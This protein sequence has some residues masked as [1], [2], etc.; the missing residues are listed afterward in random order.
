M[1]IG[2][3]QLLVIAVL[4]VM[5]FGASRL[6]DVGRGLGQGVRAFKRGM[7]G[8]PDEDAKPT[9]S[10]K[11][12]DVELVEE[13]DPADVDEGVPMRKRIAARKPPAKKLA[14]KNDP[15]GDERS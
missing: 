2:P 10:Q 3:L 4:V 11:P 6:G 7:Q 8:E 9:L 13:A 12:T 1:V 14:E 5:F 15:E